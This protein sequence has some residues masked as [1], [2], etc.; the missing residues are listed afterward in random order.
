MSRVDKP[1]DRSAARLGHDDDRYQPARTGSDAH[2]LAQGEQQA[3][4]SAM[5]R[6]ARAR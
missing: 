6:C 4:P 1:G 5:A 3:G 2:R